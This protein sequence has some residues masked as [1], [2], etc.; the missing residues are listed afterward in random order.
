MGELTERIAPVAPGAAII[1]VE[2][3]VKRYRKGKTNAVDG[4]SFSVRSGEFFALLGPNGAGK[5][6]TISILTTTL[7]PTSGRV[8]I[9]GNDVVTQ[10]SSVR[11]QVGIIFQNPSLDMNLTGEENVRFHAVLYGLYPYRP[12][13]RLMPTAYRQQVRELAALLSIEADIF[14]PIKVLSGGTRRKLEIIRSLMH[15]PAVLFLDEPT[16][17]LDT[18]G[19]RNLWEY[20]RGVQA[21]GTTVFLTTHYLEEAEAADSVC[22]IN[23]GR[24]VS[25]GP[26]SRIKAE[27]V[28]EH[29]LIDADD[30][31]R[32]RAELATRGVAF[33]ETPLF[34]IKLDGRSAHQLLKAIDTPLSVVTIHQPSLEDAYLSIIGKIDD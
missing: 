12:Q 16:R 33:A 2:D 3:L 34:K 21:A 15:R 20:L 6:T 24:I 9:G 19:R 4:I 11:R 32:L 29:V 28:S 5:T 25:F 18:N 30:R 14:R 27:L 17:G 31:D 26:P 10:A 22:I 7:I 1:E 13:F 8:R 23:R